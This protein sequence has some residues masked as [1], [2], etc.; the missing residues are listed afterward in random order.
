MKLKMFLNHSYNGFSI[1]E[2]MIAIAIVAGLAASLGPGY[3]KYIL[4]AKMMEGP[5]LLTQI[6]SAQ[7]EVYADTGT[8]V[9][10]TFALGLE[11][12]RRGYFVVGFAKGTNNGK[13][14]SLVPN[15]V[16]SSS[17][18]QI[19]ATCPL[20]NN[21][22]KET[23]C[24]YTQVQTNDYM[25]IPNTLLIR[26]GG[27][28]GNTFRP[29]LHGSEV[30]ACNPFPILRGVPGGPDDSGVTLSSGPHVGDKKGTWNKDQAFVACTIAALAPKSLTNP[31]PTAFTIDQDKN[32]IQSNIGF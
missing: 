31:N 32:L 30:S 8:Y 9:A 1:L 20:I 12:E 6:Y 10:C 27:N 19:E 5:I 28:T 4:R 29:Y 15:C 25:I 24:S 17:S 16:A 13:G 22:S 14:P 2:L 21:F 18:N 11:P 7:Q 26:G 23:E 3:E